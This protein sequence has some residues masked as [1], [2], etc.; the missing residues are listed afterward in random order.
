M[1]VRAFLPVRLSVLLGPLRVLRSNPEV[2]IH[3]LFS[4]GLRKVPRAPDRPISATETL[5]VADLSTRPFNFDFVGFSDVHARG[6]AAETMRFSHFLWRSARVRRAGCG[7]R[8]VSALRGAQPLPPTP[9]VGGALEVSGKSVRASGAERTTCTARGFAP[10][11]PRADCAPVRKVF[12][13]FVT[14]PVGRVVRRAC[15]AFCPFF[16]AFAA[17]VRVLTAAFRS[18]NLTLLVRITG[19]MSLTT[20]LGFGAGLILAELLRRSTRLG[21]A[22]LGVAR[23]GSVRRRQEGCSA[24]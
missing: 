1:T 22:K 2:T 9:S 11:R 15:R 19:C 13:R 4:T 16:E 17:F 21:W 10:T 18:W 6:T 14:K 23:L 24:S 7:P 3:N 20:C 12:F 8:A 5:L